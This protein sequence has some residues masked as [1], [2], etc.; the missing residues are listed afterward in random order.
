MKIDTG[1]G[2]VLVDKATRELMVDIDDGFNFNVRSPAQTENDKY[3]AP[4]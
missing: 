1:Q 3:W 2:A 4:K